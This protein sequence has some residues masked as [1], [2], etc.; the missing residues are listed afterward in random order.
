VPTAESPDLSVCAQEPIH[1]PGGVQAYGV[2]IA[3]DADDR[4]VSI[5]AN[6]G[7]PFEVGMPLSAVLPEWIEPVIQSSWGSPGLDGPV[8]VGLLPRLNDTPLQVLAHV[9]HGVKYVELIPIPSESTANINLTDAARRLSGLH[10]VEQFAESICEVLRRETG[11]DRVMVYR[12]DGEWNGEVLAEAKQDDLEPYLGL[13]YPASDIPPQARELYR[14]VRVRVLVDAEAPASPLHPGRG[15]TFDLSSARLRAMSPVHCEYLRN[16][17]VRATHV[18]SIFHNGDL[19]GLIACHHRQPKVPHP[20]WAVASD[21]LSRLMETAITM[22]EN[23]DRTEGVHFA[24][25]MLRSLPM[26]LAGNSRLGEGLVS[27]QVG[28]MEMMHA[29]GLCVIH[30][31]EQFRRGSAPSSERIQKLTKWLDH[32]GQAHFS[33]DRLGERNPDF[34]GDTEATGLLALHIPNSLQ[35]WI[36]WF[37]REQS[38]NV[39][40]AG[41]P[42]KAVLPAEDGSIRLSPRKSFAEWVEVVRNRSKAWS[43]AELSTAMEVIRPNLLEVVATA[44]QKQAEVLR[45]Y[46]SIL[47]EQVHDAVVV[48]DLDGVV[49][50]WNDGATRTLGWTSAEMVGKPILSRIPNADRAGAQAILAQVQAGEPFSGRYRDS[51]KSGETVWLDTRLRRITDEHGKLI[52]IMGASRDVTAEKKVEDQLRLKQ[53][54][55]RQARDNILVTE[56]EFSPEL[57]GHRIIYANPSLLEHTGYTLVEVVGKTPKIFQGPGTDRE[58]ITRIR[59]ALKSWRPVR[60]ELLNVRKDGTAFWMEIDISPLADATGWYTHWIGVQ[61]DVT[62]RRRTEQELRASAERFRAL[63]EYGFDAFNVIDEQGRSIASSPR[64]KTL[65]APLHGDAR[66]DIFAYVMTEDRPKAE[67]ALRK[68]LANP[69]V[70]V[71]LQARIRDSEGTI[72]WVESTVRNMLHHPAVRGVVVNWRDMTEQ[73]LAQDAQ[74]VSEENYAELIDS[75]DVMIWELDADTLNLTYVSKR[76]ETMLG[77][78]QQDWLDDPSLWIRFLHPDDAARVEA[79]YRSFLHDGKARVIEFRSFN[80]KGQLLWLRD[81]GRLEQRPGEANRIV[82]YTQDITEQK[83]AEADTAQA[84][85]RYRLLADNITDVISMIE[86]DGTLLFNSPSI[87]RMAG[88]TPDEV[89]G[90]SVDLLVHPDDLPRKIEAR[91]ANGLGQTTQVEWRLVCK[92]GQYLWVETS[93]QPMANAEG[94]VRYTLCCT[95]NIHQRKE[96]EQ[97]IRLAQKLEAIGQLAGGIAHD[98]NNL[99][100]VIN[101]NSELLMMKLPHDS[102]QRDM[103]ANVLRAGERGAGLTR[104]LLTFSRH[105]LIQHEVFDPLPV[106]RGTLVMMG[107][108][109]GEDIRIAPEATDDIGHI[110]TDIG[111]F[112]Q[113]LVNLAVNARDAMPKGGTLGVALSNWIVSETD[114]LLNP[115][116]P[117][118]HYVRLSVRDTGTGM[119]PEVQAR[120]FEPFFTTKPLGKGTGLGLATVYGIVRQAN[121]FIIIE[122]GLGVGSTFHIH[123]PRHQKQ[124]PAETPPPS[125]KLAAAPVN[126][127]T[128]LIVEDDDAVR[129]LTATVLENAGFTVRLA[130]TGQEA[131]AL[132]DS[133]T[134]PPD[135]VMTDVVMPGMNGLELV[136]HLIR[137]YPDLKVAFLSGYTADTVERYSVE[138]KKVEYLQKPYTPDSLTRFVRDLLQET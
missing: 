45:R 90:K 22:C 40:W 95:R 15:R 94:V 136:Q 101:G 133:V 12:F 39:R 18:T 61:R 33:T 10:T 80:D 130:S 32:Q 28:L 20:N 121:G 126:G 9:H 108:L 135:L 35:G 19:W 29:D 107:R 65:L 75:V 41:D 3:C 98:F 99:L 106:V 69:E 5:S 44:Y 16:M 100:T 67:D 26:L 128:I 70:P 85:E 127:G 93:S 117:T 111:Q 116:R 60:E 120:L 123:F 38:R 49:T 104:Q 57:G 73:K 56:A 47:F 86:L 34:D 84:N 74:R 97:Q 79:H 51:T 64:N 132:Y 11:Y 68:V 50:F 87:T 25:S 83:H 59:R 118:G 37:R 58:A 52:G 55:V 13:M 42:R 124:D 6:A 122:S 1:T 24:Q 77:C 109:L 102:P 36:L 66:H 78:R 43:V 113:V 96:L 125:S 92:S 114:T 63:V 30:R 115:T 112:E 105:Q 62:E 91:V 17:G 2:L 21:S 48:T 131:L 81:R 119:T 110:R 23:R 14:R 8:V 76:V 46:Q 134:E 4:L 53:A 71:R 31:S 89:L 138:D 82:G 27:E 7:V 54:I 137:R 88:Y 103:L 129:S 72:R